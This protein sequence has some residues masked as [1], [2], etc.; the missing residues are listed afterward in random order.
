MKRCCC[1][2]PHEPGSAA[3]CENDADHYCK[4]CVESLITAERERCAKIA[5]S[6]YAYCHNEETEEC[7][8]GKCDM[9]MARAI[10]RLIRENK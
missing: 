3:Y 9:M 10:A 6:Q 4:E 7:E 2:T 5:E 8:G 1:K